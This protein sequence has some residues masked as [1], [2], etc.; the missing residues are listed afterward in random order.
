MRTTKIDL[1][2]LFEDKAPVERDAVNDKA[3]EVFDGVVDETRPSSNRCVPRPHSRRQANHRKVPAER[4]NKWK[5]GNEGVEV[6]IQPWKPARS[7]S[8]NAYYW[9]YLGVIAEETGET[10]CTSCLNASF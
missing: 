8:Q 9:V 1:G 4:F 3:V 2:K 7:S 5:R 10:T 6:V